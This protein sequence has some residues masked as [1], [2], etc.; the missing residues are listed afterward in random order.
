MKSPAIIDVT[1]SMMSVCDR[2]RPAPHGENSIDGDEAD[3]LF[4]ESL[5]AEANRSL[6]SL[7]AVQVMLDDQQKETSVCVAYRDSKLPIGR[8]SGQ[9]IPELASRVKELQG[10]LF[11]GT[12]PLYIPLPNQSQRVA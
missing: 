1:R 4:L 6:D 2:T 8:I 9:D 12:Q 5:V 10:L 7:N 11:D 3:T